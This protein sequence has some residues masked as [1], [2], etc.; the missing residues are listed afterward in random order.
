MFRTKIDFTVKPQQHVSDEERSLI[1]MGKNP[2]KRSA[3][4]IVAVKKGIYPV[5][6]FWPRKWWF[7]KEYFR[8]FRFEGDFRPYPA[9]KFVERWPLYKNIVVMLCY[10]L[11][12]P[13]F[14]IGIVKLFK[15]NRQIA[16]FIL[17][18]ILVQALLH[19][20]QWGL[21]RYR[22]PTDVFLIMGAMYGLNSLLFGTQGVVLKK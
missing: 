15:R 7:L 10:G 8:P 12:W 19:F 14:F 6:D 22:A 1:M 18:P 21:P 9:D 5:T 2:N 17:F 20:L 3:E 4:L 16:V 11:L 13:F